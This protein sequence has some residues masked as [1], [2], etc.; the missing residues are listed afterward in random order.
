MAAS[1]L[2][3]PGPR[4]TR[5]LPPPQNPRLYRGLDNFHPEYP[6]VLPALIQRFHEKT[7]ASRSEMGGGDNRQKAKMARERNLKK[8]KARAKG[9]LV[10][11]SSKSDGT[12]RKLM[13]SSKLAEM[14]WSAKIG[15]MGVISGLTGSGGAMGA[16]MIQLVAFSGSRFSQDESISLMGIMDPY[17]LPTTTYPPKI[18]FQ[19][20]GI[21]SLLTPTNKT[22]LSSITPKKLINNGS[23][24]LPHPPPPHRRP[25]PLLHRALD[26]LQSAMDYL[27]GEGSEMDIET[28]IE[29]AL[30]DVSTCSSEWEESGMKDFPLEE[31][32]K[33]LESVVGIVFDL[34]R[35][36][37]GVNHKH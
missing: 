23:L 10:W 3:L 20:S 28:N 32:D 30:T 25:P 34:S 16:V 15:S 26:D 1:K 11:D 27:K 13:D 4:R 21:N 9:E 37:E 2:P 33:R 29:A 18:Q 22:S 35:G 5:H 31:V 17:S 14:G 8:Q 7:I 6:H 36:L 19:T 24:L 12:L